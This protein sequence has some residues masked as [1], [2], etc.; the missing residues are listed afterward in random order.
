MANF[1]RD[2][3]IHASIGLLDIPADHMVY[4][5]VLVDLRRCNKIN[6]LDSVNLR[7]RRRAWTVLGVEA[8]WQSLSK[9]HSQSFYSLFTD[10]I[11]H[12]RTR[13]VDSRPA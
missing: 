6:Y 13:W 3:H 8:L 9:T 4:N 1:V 11:V 7:L 5:I 10:R 2:E 12:L